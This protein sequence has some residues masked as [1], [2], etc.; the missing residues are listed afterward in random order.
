IFSGKYLI[1]KCIRTIG[2]T[3]DCEVKFLETTFDSY[4]PN[5]FS[6][7]K[8][9]HGI[10]N[11]DIKIKSLDWG[12]RTI[13]VQNL[14]RLRV[15]KIKLMRNHKLEIVGVPNLRVFS[16]KSLDNLKKPLPFDVDSLRRLS[17]LC[18]G[19]VIL[20]KD[21][22]DMINSKFP[23]LESLTLCSIRFNPQN[24]DIRCLTVKRLSLQF[25]ENMQYNVQ[26]YAPRL[27]LFCY[28]GYTIP[29]LLFPTITPEQ[30]KLSLRL[31]TPIELT[32]FLKMRNILNISSKFDIEILLK[33]SNSLVPLNTSLT[34][35]R[36]RVPI[37]A[38]N[39]QQ[40]SILS[41]SDHV[42]WENSLLFDTFFSICHPTYV[43]VYQNMGYKI[44]TYHSREIMFR[45]VMEKKIEKGNCCDLTGVEIKIPCN[46]H[47]KIHFSDGVINTVSAEWCSVEFEL[48]WHSLIIQQKRGVLDRIRSLLSGYFCLRAL[49]HTC[50]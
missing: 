23:F 29:N 28:E 4:G 15:M 18:L 49:Y 10:R 9:R 44:N 13:K 47:D 14:C 39:V 7:K 2:V 16:Y 6:K 46:Q 32:I 25:E 36:K 5:P 35:L 43:K 42:L 30:I 1:R 11:H 19:C 48:H 40:L 17:H 26:V 41:V 20:N 22:S 50:C 45:E 33:P 38:T 27:V 21:F 31:D 3:K 8:S 37:P 24:L 34:E 12:L